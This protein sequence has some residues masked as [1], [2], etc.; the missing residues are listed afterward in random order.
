MCAACAG[1]SLFHLACGSHDTTST[2]AAAL[3]EAAISS[4]GEGNKY[5]ALEQALKSVDRDAQ[6]SRPHF[7]VLYHDL[8]DLDS[9]KA[10]MRSLQF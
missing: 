9:A 6:L 3:L 4:Y 1:S 8:G 5:L 7:D 10:F 2:E